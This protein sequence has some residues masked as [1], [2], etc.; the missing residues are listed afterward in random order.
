MTG[1]PPRPDETPRFGSIWRWG[2]ID[3][4]VSYVALGVRELPDKAVLFVALR[5]FDG[6][7]NG[8]M[9]WRNSL[10]QILDQ[11]RCLDEGPA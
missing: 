10:G 6:Q 7:S 1:R 11:W 8:P 3:G 4:G 2:D 5:T 9:F